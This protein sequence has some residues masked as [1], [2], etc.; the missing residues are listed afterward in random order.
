MIRSDWVFAAL[1]TGS[2]IPSCLPTVTKAVS[3]RSMICL[4]QAHMDYGYMVIDLRSV[5][6]GRSPRRRQTKMPSSSSSRANCTLQGFLFDVMMPQQGMPWS[7]IL[8]FQSDQLIHIIPYSSSARQI[9]PCPRFVLILRP[10]ECHLFWFL[11][12]MSTTMVQVSS[13]YLHLQ[14]LILICR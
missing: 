3:F 5:E 6:F 4:F 13:G 7:R 8:P 2:S 14:R 11:P 12:R 10:T 9:S 1:N